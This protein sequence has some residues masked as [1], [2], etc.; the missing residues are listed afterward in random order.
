MAELVH[1]RNAALLRR[2]REAEGADG[3]LALPDVASWDIFPFEGEMR[4]KALDEPELPEPARTG[5]GGKPCDSCET[6]VSQAV[7]ADERWKITAPEPSAIPIVFLS[8]RKHVDLGNLGLLL[9]GEMGQRIWRL[10]MALTSLGG[11]G[12]VHMNRW[13]DGGAHLHLW[14]FARPEGLLQL[15][16]SSLADWTDTLP[17]MPP[18]EWQEMLSA[19]AAEMAVLGGKAMR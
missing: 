7:W 2:V 3:R 14:F 6:G 19:V 15:R 13:G 12:R 1:P 16:G 4:V 10:E 8:P 18:H 11:V 5:E 17:A 9:S